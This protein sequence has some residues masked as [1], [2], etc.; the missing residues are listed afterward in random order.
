MIKMQNLTTLIKEKYNISYMEANKMLYNSKLYYALED[1][2]TKMWYFSNK[3]L[4]KMI[5]EENETGTYNV[6]W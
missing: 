1:E 2:E 3:A 4:L 6:G 5:I